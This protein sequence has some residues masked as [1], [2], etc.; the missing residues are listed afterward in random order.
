VVC[1]YLIETVGL[2]LIIY[3]RMAQPVK[4]HTRRSS[5]ASG[6]ACEPSTALTTLKQM[7]SKTTKAT[8]I[9]IRQY[10]LALSWT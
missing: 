3:T 10:A 1:D 5:T 9:A 4:T 2:R 7:K 8:E 6:D